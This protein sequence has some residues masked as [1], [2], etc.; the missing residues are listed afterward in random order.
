MYLKQI[1]NPKDISDFFHNN[2]ILAYLG[3][4]DEA[5]TQ[6]YNTG[7]YVML[8]DSL[9][10]GAYSDDDILV[11]VCKFENFTSMCINS[12]YYI[13]RDEKYKGCN[14]EIAS[15]VYKWCIENTRAAKL[16]IMVPETCSHILKARKFF[17]WK[18]EGTIKKC[19]IWRKEL[20]DIKIF[21]L[22]LKRN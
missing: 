15:L 2:P 8:P 5:V 11:G 21:G 1:D 3:L 6:L 13:S 17:G 16:I 14:K 9:Y 22:E 20:V 12:H 7:E 10:L 19:L 18:Y 4:S